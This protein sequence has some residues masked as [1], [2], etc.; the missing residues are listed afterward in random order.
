VV[1]DLLELLVVV[2]Y[3]AVLLVVAALVVLVV[4][5]SVVVLV[6][7]V[8]LLPLRAIGDKVSGVAALKVAPRW[9]PPLLAKLVQVMELPCEQSNLIIG[10]A[11]ILLIR[12][13]SQRRQGKLQSR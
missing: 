12:S 8:K 9:S 6:G 11:L 1:H 3:K 13:C 7:D 2:V 10:D 4:P 5:V